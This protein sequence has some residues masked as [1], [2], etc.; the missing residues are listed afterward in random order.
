MNY[1]CSVVY[2]MWAI[3]RCHTMLSSTPSGHFANETFMVPTMSKYAYVNEGYGTYIQINTHTLSDL[4]LNS[5]N[6]HG[7]GA[8]KHTPTHSF[9]N[10]LPKTGYVICC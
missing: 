2:C 6:P 7:V 4:F 1:L 8:H 9:R 5:A 10:S 3:W